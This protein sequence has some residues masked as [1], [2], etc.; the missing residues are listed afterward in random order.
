MTNLPEV[1]MSVLVCAGKEYVWPWLM[2]ALRKLDYPHEKL[3]LLVLFDGSCDVAEIFL[4]ALCA[5]VRFVV[6]T[7][8]AE[9]PERFDN[10][11]ANVTALYQIA[12]RRFLDSGKPW[13][14]WLE[15]D[16]V[17]PP[18]A[19]RRLVSHGEPYVAV[20]SP[21]RVVFSRLN[22]PSRDGH[23]GMMLSDVQPGELQEV[24]WSGLGCL[25]TRRDVIDCCVWQPGEAA[26]DKQ[27]GES[28]AREFGQPALLDGGVLVPHCNESPQELDSVRVNWPRYRDGRIQG[29]RLVYNSYDTPGFWRPRKPIPTLDLPYDLTQT[30][31]VFPG[32][33]VRL[34]GIYEERG[35]A[36]VRLHRAQSAPGPFWLRLL[37][38]DVPECNLFEKE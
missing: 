21:S 33:R 36:H 10:R 5:E 22:V 29:E 19:L 6:L 4:D 11:G 18:G 12:Q 17:P 1:W 16:Q 3:T 9:I 25:L 32:E 31:I 26:P 35:G 20:T 15:C 30:E 27:L 14:W 28:F 34:A 2:D 24:P 13:C 38:P 37:E 8:H 7:E 23:K